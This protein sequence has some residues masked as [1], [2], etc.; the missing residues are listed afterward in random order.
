[1]TGFSAKVRRLVGARAMDFNDAWPVCEV[2]AECHG[3]SAVAVHHRRPRA[4]GGSR[5]P[6]T[7]RAANG[8]AVCDADHAWIESFR[9]QAHR[10]G[11]LLRQQ[12]TPSEVPVLRRGVWVLLDDAG[13]FTP[14]PAPVQEVTA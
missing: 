11:W 5:R 7:N 6:E 10:Y 1:M 9:E 3:R 14:V 8:L 13:G 12:Q 4:A 2:M